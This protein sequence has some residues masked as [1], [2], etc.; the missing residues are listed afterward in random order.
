M[1]VQNDLLNV[2]CRS[3]VVVDDGHAGNG[4]QQRA[5]LDLIGP[6]CIDDNEQAL[7]VCRHERVFTRDKHA[8]KIGRGLELGKQA[9]GDVLFLVHHDLRRL[10]ALAAQAAD[11]DRRAQ[12]I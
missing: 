5:R 4:L 1:E 12:C 10:S 3:S 9:P 7:R 8:G 6:V 11:T 2:I